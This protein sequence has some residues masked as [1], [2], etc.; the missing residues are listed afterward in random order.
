MRRSLYVFAVLAMLSGPTTAWSAKVSRDE[1]AASAQRTTGGRVLSVDK[2]EQ[3]G[4]EVYRV[5]ILTPKGEVRIVL[6]DADSGA[7][8]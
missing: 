4:R 6:V 3:G 1:A 8:Q 5:K 7:V 2:A